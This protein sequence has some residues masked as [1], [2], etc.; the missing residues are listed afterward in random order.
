M[1]RLAIC[2]KLSVL[3]EYLVMFEMQHVP[4]NSSCLQMVAA[5]AKENISLMNKKSSSLLK[6]SIQSILFLLQYV[7][8]R[9]IF[10]RSLPL[11]RMHLSTNVSST[12]SKYSVA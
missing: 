11:F 8:L 9:N 5:E 6:Y 2:S 1:T 3:G 4:K 10:F 12:T 7:C